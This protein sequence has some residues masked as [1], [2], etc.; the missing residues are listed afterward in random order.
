MPVAAQVIQMR[1]SGEVAARELM[2]EVQPF[3]DKT[4]IRAFG[5]DVLIAVYDRSGKQ[6]AGGLWIA[7]T[8][9]EDKFQGKVG[10]IL[11]MGPLCEGPE[12]DAWFGDDPPKVGD[13]IGVNI[14]DG[15]AMLLGK[16][17]CRLVEWKYLRFPTAVPDLTM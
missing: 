14:R 4:R 17:T 13:W 16:T 1:D 8:N 2:S 3:L 10:L 7:E 6:T 11:S 12:F 9:E 15:M 5:D